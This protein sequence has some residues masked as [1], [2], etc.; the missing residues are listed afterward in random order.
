MVNEKEGRIDNG[1]RST[2]HEPRNEAIATRKRMLRV[3]RNDAVPI[4]QPHLVR[5]RGDEEKRNNNR[6]GVNDKKEVGSAQTIDNGEAT[7][8]ATTTGNEKKKRERSRRRCYLTTTRYRVEDNGKEG[9]HTTARCAGQRSQR[10]KEPTTG[11][12][13]Q[14]KADIVDAT[15]MVKSRKT[16]RRVKTTKP[17][18]STR[19]RQQNC[20]G[21]E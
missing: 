21:Y 9:K 13:H 1:T 17:I 8:N 20:C 3:G 2:R 5:K 18:R 6:D 12:R 19:R 11:E 14:R 10:E 16:A 7:A 4:Q 15:D